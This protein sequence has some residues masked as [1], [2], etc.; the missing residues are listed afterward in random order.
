MIAATILTMYALVYLVLH[1]VDAVEE[2][3]TQVCERKG[4]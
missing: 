4:E 2:G 3:V 1:V